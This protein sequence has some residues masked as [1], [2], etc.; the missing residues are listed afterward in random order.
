MLLSGSYSPFSRSTRRAPIHTTSPSR[1]PAPPAPVRDVVSSTAS[2]LTARREAAG[3]VRNRHCY[4]ARRPGVKPRGARGE[5]GGHRLC[6]CSS[7]DVIQLSGKKRCMIVCVPATAVDKQA[8]SAN[9]E[10][11]RAAPHGCGEVYGVLST[12]LVLGRKLALVTGERV[13]GAR[14]TGGR[15]LLA[16]GRIRRQSEP[17]RGAP[18]PPPC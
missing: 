11:S 5:S 14:G 6:I 9:G 8:H 3:C 4:G 2:K 7:L 17:A 10:P 13:K 15:G 16:S 18:P 12:Q 1:M